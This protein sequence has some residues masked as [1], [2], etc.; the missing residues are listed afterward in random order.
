[1]QRCPASFDKLSDNCHAVG[2]DGVDEEEELPAGKPPS[3]NGRG[4]MAF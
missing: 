1:M 2:R 4:L 3:A